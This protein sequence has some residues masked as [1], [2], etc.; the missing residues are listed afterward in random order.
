MDE[1]KIM[2]KISFY[3]VGLSFSI[4][5]ALVLCEILSRIIFG[6]VFRNDPVLK[7]NA[8]NNLIYQGNQS[9]RFISFEW[10]VQIDI[11]SFGF[12]DDEGIYENGKKKILILGDS[13]TE[14]F[15]V[16]HENTFSKKLE[17]RLIKENFNYSVLNAGITGNN[18]VDYV[19]IYNTY[20]KNF[21]DIKVVLIAL[22]V[23]NDLKDNNTLRKVTNLKKEKLFF[24]LKYFAAKNS[25]FYNILNRSVKSN[26]KIRKVL[27][28]IGIIKEKESILSNYDSKNKKF[29]KKINYSAHL[30]NKFKDNNKKKRI[31]VALIPSK[32]QIDDNYWKFLKQ[33]K[34]N[35]LPKLNRN[36][37]TT[38][39]QEKLNRYGVKFINFETIF[40]N[41]I[42]LNHPIYFKYDAHTNENGHE[43]MA[44]EI[45]KM[46]KDD[47]SNN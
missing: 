6:G 42:K 12:R 11:N 14:G 39:M 24:R 32:E 40:N 35:N 4:I 28:K 13:F 31:L 37:P 41:S 10:D 33:I 29:L 38:L 45:F 23:G 30:I 16:S 43:I 8:E 2:K 47:L 1:K 5:L 18:L 19:E 21:S 26:F 7:R 20:F 3:I 46:I 9:S 25:T 44:Q 17:K 27:T 15:G 34:N 36:L 22:F